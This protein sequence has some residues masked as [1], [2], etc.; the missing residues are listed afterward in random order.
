MP[1]SVA[2]VGTGVLREG[3]RVCRQSVTRFRVLTLW[4]F[5]Q[6][7]EL[8]PSRRRR[9]WGNLSAFRIQ[10]HEPELQV[11]DMIFHAA[12]WANLDYI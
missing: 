5:R 6:R 7:P 3:R 1:S 9:A 11:K 8:G 12:P 10:D 4:G 2:S